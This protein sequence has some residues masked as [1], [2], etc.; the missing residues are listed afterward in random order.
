VK[1]EKAD[2]LSVPSG[3][4]YYCIETTSIHACPDRYPYKST[5]Y[6]TFRKNGGIMERVYEIEEIVIF[7]PHDFEQLSRLNPKCKSRIQLYMDCRERELPFEH[8]NYDRRFYILS[9]TNQI[10]LTHKPHM[11]KNSQGHCYFTLAELTSG[12]EIVEVASKQL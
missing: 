11:R 9:E 12:K 5:P 8:E 2:V 4:S 6:I 7:N 3:S 1:S 10:E